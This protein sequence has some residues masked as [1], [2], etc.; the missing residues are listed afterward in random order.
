MK[1]KI[2]L[3]KIEY[4]SEQ[5]EALV[6]PIYKDD[7]GIDYEQESG[8]QFFRKKLSG[9]LMFVRKDYDTISKAP[10][11]TEFILR[12][13]QLSLGIWNE[14]Y[15]GGFMKTDCTIDVD[16][17]TITVQP[18]TIDEYKDIMSGLEMEYDLVKLPVETQ[19]VK[20]YKRP[21]IQ[22]YVPGENIVS[23]FLGG[24]H[25]EQDAEV[26]N[27]V[28]TLKN[29]YKFALNSQMR[30]IEVSNASI[31]GIN[32]VYA[33]KLGGLYYNTNNYY[34]K[35]EVV[36]YGETTANVFSIYD[37]NK[38]LY[39]TEPVEKLDPA[40]FLKFYPRAGAGNPTSRGR[41]ID[42][43]ARYVCDVDRIDD[44]STYPIPND[45][46]VANNRNYKRVIGF[47]VA[48][49]VVASS[50]SSV[51][52]TPWGK[53]ESGR[54]YLPPYSLSNQRFYPI[55]RSKWG[56]VSVWFAFAVMD[57]LL[58]AKARKAYTL[59]NTYTLSSCIEELLKIVAPGITHK[60]KA[61][62]S[63]FLYGSGVYDN[64]GGHRGRLLISPKSN[65]LNGEYQT[66]AQKAPITL[67][68]IFDL[69]KN[70]YKCYWYVENGKL[71][72]EQIE[73][74]RN[75][76]TYEYNPVIGY[77]LT[78]LENP[79]NGKKLAFGTSQY[80]YDKAEM[81]ERYDFEWMD[82]ATDVFTGLPI[83]SVS[84]YVTLGK[85]EKI[86]VANFTSD[87]DL[88]LL[89]PSGFSED[90]FAV[91]NAT[92]AP[93]SYE[94]PILEKTVDNTKYSLQNGWLAYIYLQPL[95]WLYNMPAAH[96]QVNGRA[97]RARSIERLKKQTVKFPANVNINPIALIKTQ[98]GVGEIEK[99]N[100]NLSSGLAKS[101]LKY[102][103]E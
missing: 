98:L 32:G 2:T 1:Y 8:Q 67:R 36:P 61:E 59:R 6:F 17:N 37:D 52:P 9:K 27:D 18:S 69:L 65:I 101:Q 83:V 4:G 24:T 88:M 25:W 47:A 96:L 74:F 94:L 91:F 81:P 97:E 35:G 90:G 29:K 12:I 49:I 42:V 39:Q 34:I 30:E 102:D 40:R 21:L 100:V 22:M 75:G 82:D 31:V 73:F 68:T 89:N 64:T 48:N 60:A 10:F 85:L 99:I 77:D 76:G 38:L 19:P 16:N 23:C 71:K 46:I 72:I 54:Y 26:V 62:Y 20:L 45:D 13:Y 92:G 7:L 103:T 55:G 79:R 84:K 3:S 5:A 41:S 43:Y 33:G 15:K 28:T 87:I 58:E 50:R 53:G 80:N 44:L 86:N 14:V 93:G 95:Y 11:E 57:W 51:A 66:P 78:E 63:E 56:K 70:V